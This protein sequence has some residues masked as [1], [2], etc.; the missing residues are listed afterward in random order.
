MPQQR[1]ASA[2]DSTAD[3]TAMTGNDGSTDFDLA[4]ESN[5]VLAAMDDAAFTRAVTRCLASHRKIFSAQQNNWASVRL[6]AN[7]APTLRGIAAEDAKRKDRA[8]ARA[9]DAIA[10]RADPDDPGF[11]M[12]DPYRGPDV[13]TVMVRR[14]ENGASSAMTEEI[15]Q[16]LTETLPAVKNVPPYTSYIYS[17]HENSYVQ[18]EVHRRLMLRDNEGELYQELSDSDA[19]ESDSK[20]EGDELGS[21]VDGLGDESDGTERRARR[22]TAKKEGKKERVAARRGKAEAEENV[23]EAA[24]IDEAAAKRHWDRRTD[25]L[26][27]AAAVCLGTTTRCIEAVAANLRLDPRILRARM[28]TLQKAR[29]HARSGGEKSE[30]I[31]RRGASNV[32]AIHEDAKAAHAA[33]VRAAQEYRAALAAAKGDAKF[34]EEEG[35][36]EEG[37]VEIKMDPGSDE[38]EEEVEEEEEEEEGT[39]SDGKKRG[40]GGRDKANVKDGGDASQGPEITR[41]ATRGMADNADVAPVRRRDSRE[42]KLWNLVAWRFLAEPDWTEDVNGGALLRHADV[43]PALDSFR[44]LYCPRC[45]HYDCNL[46]GCGHA[47]PTVKLGEEEASRNPHHRS[48]TH[49]EAARRAAKEAEEAAAAA[50]AAGRKTRG[51][52]DRPALAQPPCGPGCWLIDALEK[53]GNASEKSVNASE[54]SVNASAD[55]PT[56]ASPIRFDAA[57]IKREAG[58]AATARAEKARAAPR[59]STR[60]TPQKQT[61][62]NT[63]TRKSPRAGDD[64][65]TVDVLDDHPVPGGVD[66]DAVVSTPVRRTD[67]RGDAGAPRWS[68]F[69]ESYYAKMR[70]TY[71][72]GGDPCAIAR[73]IDGPPC[74]E[75]YRRL[76]ADLQ[77]EGEAEASR[78]EHQSDA[79]DEEGR[80]GGG[81][82]GGGRRKGGKRRKGWITQRKRTSIAVIRRRMTN[83]ED[84]VWTQYTPCECGPGGC[85]ARTCACMSDGNFCEKYCSCRGPLSRCAN[86]F[87]GC[88][89][90]SGTCMTRACPC[91]A[92]ARECDPDICKRCAHTAETIAH[93]RRDG[94][95]FTDICEPVPAPP[96]V[97]VE[98]TA[99]RTDPNEQC[100][101]MKLYLRQHKHAC[102][103]LS[104]VE[105]WGCFLKNG[106][107]KNELLGEYTGELISQTEADRRGKIY[108]KLNSSFL[109]NLN[110]QWVLDAAVRGNKLKFANHSA[111]PNCYAKVLMVR[112]DHRVGI[113][114]KEHIAPGEELT[115]DYRYEADKAPDWAL[116]PTEMED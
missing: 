21:D 88:N 80:G 39:G 14:W 73:A 45:H 78:S 54:K 44:T 41:R 103:G 3:A 28:R 1:H 57:R 19:S 114:A 64:I 56:G 91:F 69:D 10:D 106:A 71:G 63:P 104:G 46:H 87:T 20:E 12:S 95:P 55:A 16:C 35:A 97:P 109:F 5:E 15:V 76:R 108:D 29:T 79:E 85:N 48:K 100:G 74:V 67:R 81:G 43:G 70:V 115:Y 93:E 68:S 2:P 38:E 13:A 59:R 34:G 86:A 9:A 47:Q 52:I 61:Q 72:A 110:D 23:D 58:E 42:T 84:H 102:L 65:S 24:K 83:E 101:N 113:F 37:D 77:R 25:Y 49:M 53:S 96:K 111:T 30:R 17:A 82:R 26:I 90:K 107:R 27:Y 105:G 36:E 40:V 22:R 75:V 50:A 18:D 7:L 116:K 51:Q 98:A 92:A 112:G 66:A 60:G 94:W 62:T 33:G 11:E 32:A 6:A 31:D 8:T 89:C 99:A 4:L